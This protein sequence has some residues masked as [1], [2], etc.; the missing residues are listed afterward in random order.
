[1]TAKR[2]L[3]H[4][5]IQ[6]I[7]LCRHPITLLLALCLILSISI[8]CLASSINY[9]KQ[10][11]VA[12]GLLYN[13]LNKNS[14]EQASV[15]FGELG[16]YEKAAQ[17]KFYVDAITG[18]RSETIADVR[19]AQGI[20]VL[21]SGN[22]AFETELMDRHLPVCSQLEEYAKA[23]LLENEQ[24]Y[25]QAFEAYREAAVLDAVERAVALVPKVNLNDVG[26][27]NSTVSIDYIKLIRTEIAGIQKNGGILKLATP[28]EVFN[29]YSSLLFR[30]EESTY[31]TANLAV[32]SLFMSVVYC[33][34]SSQEVSANIYLV[35]STV[36][37]G[38][39]QSEAETYHLPGDSEPRM[40]CF[41]IDKLLENVKRKTST[42]PADQYT[43]DV[44]INGTVFCSNTFIVQ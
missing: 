35:L 10:Y 27:S 6:H 28:E 32:Y 24:K 21:L 33:N 42:L 5:K 12:I 13:P 22:T 9:E 14:M 36:N 43:I 25:A 3:F 31:T 38:T 4:P 44:C 37:N 20:L 1:M 16:A 41:S 39:Y 8:P 19:T 23:R 15:L 29:D 11:E 18:L 7:G 2:F 30:P 34:T 26:G 17:Y 40:L